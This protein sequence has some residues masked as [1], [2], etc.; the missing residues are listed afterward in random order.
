MQIIV[1]CKIKILVF[2]RK[3]PRTSQVC[4]KIFDLEIKDIIPRKE[5]Q[6]RNFT[7]MLL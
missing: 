1:Y 4:I 3:K 7:E 6:A 2:Y 5:K